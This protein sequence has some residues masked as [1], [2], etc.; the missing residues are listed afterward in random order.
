ME[1]NLRPRVLLVEDEMDLVFLLERALTQAGF[2]V[3]SCVEGN[4]ALARAWARPPDLC[5]LD[6]MLPGIDGT[7]ICA[8]LKADPRTAHVPVLLITAR[9]RE[10]DVFRALVEGADDCLIKPFALAELVERAQRL[11]A[12]VR[13]LSE[14]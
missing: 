1:S 2:A 7:E 11:L 5:V 8:R 10:A 14:R 9:G 6:W 3:E 4:V 13:P 12:P